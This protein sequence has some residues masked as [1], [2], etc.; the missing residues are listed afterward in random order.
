MAKT[1]RSSAVLGAAKAGLTLTAQLKNDAGTD[2]AAT[3]SVVEVGAGGN[4]EATSTDVPD[5]FVGGVVR[6]TGTGVDVMDRDGVTASLIAATT[7]PTAAAIADEVRV[8]LA[9]ELGRIDAAVSTRATPAQ[10]AAELATYDGPTNAEMVARTLAAADYAT[11]ANLA[12][13]DDFLDT[14]IADIQARLPAA[15]VGGRM[16][17]SVGAMAANTFTASALATDAVT[18]IQTGLATSAAVTAIPAAVDVTLTAAH[19]AGSW[20]TGAGSA[21]IEVTATTPTI[22][23]TETENTIEVTES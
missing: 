3:W 9:T 16:D 12:T 19:G 21:T 10:V 23:I 2:V 7:A 20:T 17:S 4:Y 13:V 5:S 6:F 11:A 8:E 18:E 1:V 22:E 15:L 14:E